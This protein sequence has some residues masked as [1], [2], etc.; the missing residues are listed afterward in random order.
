MSLESYI[1]YLNYLKVVN[2]EPELDEEVQV[3]VETDESEVDMDEAVTYTDVS[4]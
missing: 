1:A 3:D 4:G 2:S